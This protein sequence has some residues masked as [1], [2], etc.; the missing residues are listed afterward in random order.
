VLPQVLDCLE[1]LL[2]QLRLP[3]VRLDG[4]TAVAERLAIVDACVSAPAP[5][6][7]H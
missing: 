4:S 6:F 7:W 5:V 3:Y 1:W 2:Q